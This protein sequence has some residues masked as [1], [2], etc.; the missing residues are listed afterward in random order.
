MASPSFDLPNEL[1][2][3]IAHELMSDDIRVAWRLR[4]ISKAFEKA[5]AD[6]IIMY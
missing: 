3:I 4:G 6:D 5:I 1:L 2:S